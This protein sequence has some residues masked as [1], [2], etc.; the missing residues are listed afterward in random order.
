MNLSENQNPIDN[1]KLIY[2]PRTTYNTQKS[3]EN[4]LYK[5]L[6]QSFDPYTLNILRRHFKEHLG[7]ITKDIFICILKRHLLSWHPKIK[8]RPRILLKLLSQL[9][10]EIDLDSNDKINWNEFS[11]FLV[12][13]GSSRKNEDSIYF[14]RK[15]FQCKTNFDHIE[16]NEN[17]DDEKIKYMNKIGNVV[18]YCFYIQKYRFLGLIHEGKNKIIFF[19]SENQKR[20]KLEIDLSSIQDEMDKYEIFEFEYKTEVMLEK[21]QEERAKN[22][23]IIEENNRKFFLKHNKRYMTES[24]NNQNGSSEENSLEILQKNS[25]ST[26]K[27]INENNRVSTPS[28]VKKERILKSLNLKKKTNNNYKS[29]DKKNDNNN[30]IIEK[31]IFHIVN[32]LF[33]N[34]YNLLFISSTNNVISA[35]QYKEKEEYF[36]N[37]NLISQNID[38]PHNKKECVFDKNNILIPLFS[39]E[40]TQYTMCFDYVTNNLYSGQNDGKILKWEMT[41]NKPILTLDI[42][43]FNKNNEKNNLYLPKIKNQNDFNR[44]ALLKKGN[45]EFNKFLKS[46][47]ENK[48][49]TVSCLIHIDPLKLICSSHYNGLIVLWDLIYN[50]PKRIYNDQKTG[51]YQVIYD[52]S[53]NH[54]YT[55]G[56]E[57]DIFIYDPYIDNEAI[58]RLKGHKSSVNSIALIPQNNELLS[59]DILGTIKIW[60]TA[61]FM[62]FQ[63]ININESTILEANHFKSREEIY[64]K[65]YKKKLSSNIHIQTFPD[66]KKFLIYGK[67]FL[68][69]EKGDLVNPLLSDEYMIIG[70]FY[71]PKINNTITISS[72]KVKFWNIFNGKLMKTYSNLMD[73][74]SIINIKNKY[75]DMNYEITSFTYDSH[76]KKLYL[77]DSLGRIKSFYMLTGDFIKN[78]EP[79]NYEI[80]HML[81]S[82]KFDYLISC[83]SDLKLKVHKDNGQ[84]DN[85]YK[86]MRDLYLVQ[87]KI[88]EK[89]YNKIFAKKLVFDEDKSLLI[90]C[91]SNG[92]INE[93]DVEHFKMLNEI[94]IMRF[95]YDADTNVKNMAQVSSGEYI[96]DTD[97]FF[98]CLDNNLKKLIAL[99]NNKY[100]NAL[101]KE[102]IGNF[103]DK[104]ENNNNGDVS[105][106]TYTIIFSFYDNISKKLFIGDS[107]GYLISYDLSC[108]YDNLINKKFSTNEEIIHAAQNDININ[109]IFKIQIH[110]EPITYIIKPKELIP[111]ILITVSTDRT[112]KLVNF[113][114]GEYI[115]SFK[116]ISIK[117]MQFPIAVRYC[118]ENPFERFP[119]LKEEK[120]SYN[121][122]DKNQKEEDDNLIPNNI[123]EEELLNQKYY[124]YIMYRKDIKQQHESDIPK[125]NKYENR[126]QEL[127]NY[128]NAVLLHTVKEKLR[129]PKFGQQIPE[130]KSTLWNYQIDVDYL[131]KMDYESLL[132]LSKKVGNKEKEINIT[133]NNFKEFEIENNNYY[134]KYIKD[135]GQIDKDKIKD[136]ISSKI[137]EVNLAYNK[138]AKT[139]KEMNDFAKNDKNNDYNIENLLTKKTEGSN[140]FLTP[141]KP[142]K[143]KSVTHKKKYE[144]KL[145]IIEEALSYTEQKDNNNN[146]SSRNN[147]N[148]IKIHHSPN[149]YQYLGEIY[150]SIHVS[151]EDKFKGFRSEFDEKINDILGPME[152]FKLRTKKN[153]I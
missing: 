69:F 135:L 133:E 67:K 56:F 91:L 70:C 142:I 100:F 57:H 44:E 105:Y 82:N 26:D 60:D 17:F 39:T 16:K 120:T 88:S 36:E 93:F 35:W 125:I 84:K 30:Q 50:K 99:K 117:D 149:K 131:K 134:P 14:L 15:Y 7:T 20:L 73:S 107:F 106:K 31:K 114:T 87:P 77:G 1:Y 83:S 112:V 137:K 145:P 153:K 74:D 61:N 80:T 150:K 34:N 48:R 90:T 85:E 94:D 147:D 126:R 122:P 52:Y 42:N 146:K 68:L 54:I 113:N 148:N 2:S 51:I 59:V 53:K 130:E 151:T 104:N 5:D 24:R 72:K 62:N 11:N 32:T 111:S 141:L 97:T 4:N 152:F 144:D 47:P 116:Q 46:F 63:T 9:F 92:L 75:N 115:D 139:K 109:E 127:I 66:L 64:N 41:L 22:K 132:T 136:A 49:S 128:A 38:N 71:N 27:K 81:Y 10:D 6:L 8:N 29:T 55:C 37:V 23:L 121:E 79:H 103:I 45:S 89:S 123:D 65:T 129:I 33:L 140:F 78:F 40:H 119:S 118:K 102:S 101:R 13:I 58:Y 25:N 3:L 110:K 19:N 43:E 12:Y 124:P 98:I 138:R 108:L 76:F 143:T 95:F 86:V 96:K 18:S 28:T 21:Q